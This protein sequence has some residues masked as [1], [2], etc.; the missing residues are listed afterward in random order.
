MKEALLYH[1]AED[2]KVNC[3]LCHHRCLIA[4]EKVGL[5]GVHQNIEGKLYSLVYD[6]VIS[7]KADPVEKKPFFHFIPGSR[8]LS[9]ATVGC[10]FQ[11]LHCQNYQISQWPRDTRQSLEKSASEI[12][13][14]SIS[15]HEIVSLA[16]T[17][18]C[19]NIAY[20]Y[21][22]PTIYLEL[23]LETAL[24]AHQAGIKNLFVTNGYMTPQALETI[25]PYLDGANVDL[26]GFDGRKY[27]QVCGGHLQ[28]ILEN[29]QQMRKMNIWLEVTT[30]I[31]PGHNDSEEEIREMAHFLGELGKEIPWHL[32]VFHPTYRMTGR[33]QTPLESLHRARRIGM[34]EGL[35]Y[36]YIGNA[37]GDPYEDTYCCHCGAR[38]IDRWGYQLKDYRIQRGKCPDC[39]THVDGV[40]W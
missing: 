35:R 13:G 16:Q 38:L 2:R 21:T 15:P 37:H 23:A 40:G 18:Q 19:S 11:C 12:P 26:K 39:G 7:A 9:I 32:S 6:R 17:H 14:R 34:E 4:P 5:C 20:T 30:L 22:E 27:Q 10:N 1:P 28:P 31:I 24:L 25:Q 8:S 3:N 36:V 29:I 33:P